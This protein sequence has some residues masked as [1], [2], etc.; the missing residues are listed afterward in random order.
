MGIDACTSEI[1]EV[2]PFFSQLEDRTN[3]FLSRQRKIISLHAYRGEEKFKT[4]AQFKSGSTPFISFAQSEIEFHQ[5]VITN[6]KQHVRFYDIET[7]KP[8]LHKVYDLTAEKNTN[9]LVQWNTIK[10]WRDR[11]YFYA[12]SKELYLIDPRSS[13]KEWRKNVCTFKESEFFCENICSLALSEFDNHF[14]VG[15]SHKLYCLDARNWQCT[16][17][18]K[19]TV[20]RWM[21]HLEYPPL[22]AETFR[23][24]NS[25]FISLASPVAGELH[26]FELMRSGKVE[27]ADEEEQSSSNGYNYKSLSLAYQPPTLMEAYHHARLNGKCLRPDADLKKRLGCCTTGLAY[28]IN[29]RGKCAQPLLLTSTSNGDVFGHKLSKRESQAYEPR[30]SVFTDEIVCKYEDRVCELMPPT[31]NFTDV[32]DMKGTFTRD[33]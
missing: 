20:C 31:L 33:S 19:N 11:T 3:C 24:D 8:T 5:I 25:E 15:S 30:T 7:G 14:Y 1:F 2:Q 9:D 27:N 28:Y 16:F 23:Y 4:I 13:P 22:M 10:T 29:P 32:V 12:N 21:H 17:E 6:M 26:I 18:N